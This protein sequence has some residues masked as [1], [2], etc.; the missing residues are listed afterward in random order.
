MTGPVSRQARTCAVVP[1][2]HLFL[3][4]SRD[5]DGGVWWALIADADDS[6]PG[7][8]CGPVGRDALHLSGVQMQE[9]AAVLRV[10]ED[11]R[12]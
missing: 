8:Q 9:A 2:G 6:G 10:V 7:L 11:V 1:F 12:S 4:V 3:R 5:A